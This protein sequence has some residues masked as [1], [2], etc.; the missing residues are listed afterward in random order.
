ML[1]DT[2]DKFQRMLEQLGR[3]EIIA[4]D[5]ETN[6]VTFDSRG[7]V[8]IVFGICADKDLELYPTWY[9][10]FGHEANLFGLDNNLP[11]EWLQHLEFL[12]K[13]PSKTW[14]LHN[15]KFDFNVLSE[16][17][18]PLPVGKW[19]DTMLMFHMWNENLF[20]YGLK[21]LGKKFLD[22]DSDKEEKLLKKLHKSL[23]GN[24][25]ER[26]P[27]EA[28]SVYASKD[29]QLTIQLFELVRDYIAQSDIA[30]VFESLWEGAMQYS[31]ALRR[32]E[33]RGILIDVKRAQGLAQR[34]RLRQKEL[35]ASLG[36]DPLKPK[37][38]AQH[39]FGSPPEGLGFRP[40]PLGKPSKSFPSGQPTMDAE[41]LSTL[42][43]PDVEKI[44]EYRHHSQEASFWYEGWPALVD[45]NNVLHTNFKIHGTKNSRLSS[46]K[47]NMQQVP[48]EGSSAVKS[49]LLARP[50]FEL[51]EFDYSQ[52]ELRLA[53]C[54]GADENMV[55][56]FR[57]GG[58]IHQVTADALGITR[59]DGK[60]YNFSQLYG[61]GVRTIC[62]QL[63]VTEAAARRLK[64]AF[65]RT[66][67]GLAE[68]R[69]KATA[70][71]EGALS[72][73]MWSGRR[74]HF[75]WPSEYKDAF[76][77]AVQGGGAEILRVSLCTL[78]FDTPEFEGHVVNLVHDSFWVELPEDQIE[79]QAKVV[80]DVMEWPTDKFGIPF[81]VDA[82]RLA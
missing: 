81:P 47:P 13:D 78:L 42:D 56:A 76:N 65:A 63:G 27:P 21:E 5:T 49:L 38:L 2:E 44:L 14:V 54:Y 57:Q 4:V 3:A 64:A 20:T 6:G 25:Y 19:Y 68:A 37:R 69:S 10:P 82:K 55:N 80:K 23:G 77:A 15:A 61:G 53:A 43:H 29:A 12:F 50:G 71:A 7:L 40:G 31:E 62:R 60:T 16:A 79:Y 45:R 34:A 17:G 73:P 74:R 1:V 26:I 33:N 67:P 28:L 41:F 35:E 75:M 9:C 32:V 30:E 72:V 52:V 48:R 18:L 22:D 58:D 8:G 66:Y 46:E 59:Q 11:W 51:W 36:F 39:L 70:A 24:G